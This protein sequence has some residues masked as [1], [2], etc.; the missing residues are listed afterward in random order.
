MHG[1]PPCNILLEA[2]A[3]NSIRLLNSLKQKSVRPDWGRTQWSAVPPQL[4]SH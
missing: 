3:I 2:H 1:P 4:G